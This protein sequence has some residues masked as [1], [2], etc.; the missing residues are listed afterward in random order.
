MN[1]YLKI[2]HCLCE[3]CYIKFLYCSIIKQN[4]LWYKITRLHLEGLSAINHFEYTRCVDL[5]HL[6]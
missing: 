5:N 1:R 2:N 4:L 3:T 6:D